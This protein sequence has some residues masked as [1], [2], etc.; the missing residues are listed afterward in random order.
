M[1]YKFETEYGTISISRAVI[2][3]IITNAVRRFN[4]KVYISNT[5]GRMPSGFFTKIGYFDDT[6]NIDISMGSKGL[7]IK[8]FIIIKFGT[9]IGHVTNQLITEI[10]ENITTMT[11]EK[12]NSIAVVVK[13]TLSR[14]LQ[15]RNI[16]V[17]S[18]RE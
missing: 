12:P 14:E 18:E 2:T 7:D 3:K 16:E 4:G 9:S 13:G 1:L 5:K 10:Q 6:Q 17:K 11:G 8:F 15:R